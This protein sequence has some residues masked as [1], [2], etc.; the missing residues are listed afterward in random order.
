MVYLGGNRAGSGT[1]VSGEIIKLALVAVDAGTTKVNGT[2]PISGNGM[3]MNTT[4]TIGTITQQTGAYKTVATTTEDIGKTAFVFTSIRVTAGSQEKVLVKGIRWNQV[5]SIGQT[6]IA[7]M[8]TVLEPTG[9]TKTE[10]PAVISSDGKYYTTSFGSGVELDKGASAEIYIKGDIMSGSN[11]T[12]KF[13]IYRTSDLMVSG[14]TYGFGITPPTSGTGFT[15]S[16]PWYF[17]SQVTVSKGTLNIENSTSVPSQNV[18]VNLAGQPLGAFTVEARGESISVAQLVFNIGTDDNGTASVNAADV[19]NVSLYD[20]NGKV[21]AGPQDGA[22]ADTVTFSDTVTFPVGKHVYTLKGKYG[23]DFPSNSTVQASTTPSS[24]WTTVRGVTTGETITPAPASAISFSTM[25]V[26]AATVA[27]SVS[28]DPPAQTVVS[29]AQAFVFARYLLDSTASGEDIRMPSIP[30]EY[31]TASTATNLTSCQLFD[32]ATSVTT[33]SNII[34]PSAAASS[35]TF[36]FDGSGFTIP[37]GTVKTLDL[38]CNIASG[39]SGTYAWGYNG[40]SSP[41]A[42]GLTSGQSA[43]ITENDSAGQ[44]MTLATSGSF[45]VALDSS[46]PSYT[47]T[48]AG[49]TDVPVSVYRITTTNEAVTITDFAL[50]LTS[51]TSG[52]GASTSP[53]DV[54]R[55]TLWDGANK[56]G[57]ATFVGSSYSASTTLGTCSG[58]VAFQVPKDSSKLLTAKVDLTNQGVSQAGLPGTLVRVDW[59]NASGDA[60]KGTGVASG[61]QVQRTNSSDTAS[62]GV[63]V[64]KSYPTL[65]LVPLPNTHLTAGRVDLFRFKITAAPEGDVGVAKFTFRI[66]T[67]SATSQIDMIDNVNMYVYTDSGYSTVASGVQSDGALLASSVDLTGLVNTAGQGTS[68]VSAATDIQVWAENSSAASTTVVIPAGGTRYFSIKGDATT[69]G[70]QFSVSTQLQGDTKF[71]SDLDSTAFTPTA[72]TTFLATTTRLNTA[73]DNDFVWRPFSTTTTQSINANDYSTG[74]G[75][76]GLPNT[77][78]NAQ[79]MTQ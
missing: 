67:S 57:Q 8:K 66:A 2:L 44:L 58:C 18:A 53:T 33:G 19:T 17:G 60:T 24:D 5:G 11:R 6:D 20:E 72:S 78:T 62:D 34:N 75:I 30:L 47:L 71:V 52:A 45:T 9:G 69:A 76:P 14:Q 16:N 7:N 13:D 64:Y 43:T 31:N 46:S 50:Q 36:T 54:T 59:D 4:L 37:K 3:T 68:W 40:A 21:V 48:A 12:I 65:E 63:R 27:I 61:Q 49:R 79:I 42:T 41:T 29:G 25:T 38:K 70:T 74:Y 23:T 39:A 22:A 15:S 73:G 1:S 55:V 35:T 32:G 77:N 56:V 28:T 10:Y 26:K 51:G